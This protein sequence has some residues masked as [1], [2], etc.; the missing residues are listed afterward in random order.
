[1]WLFEIELRGLWGMRMRMTI[2]MKMSIG[3]RVLVLR[4][5][6]NS[7]HGG[8]WRCRFVVVTSK[9]KEKDPQKKKE[10]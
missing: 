10:T 9:I 3:R 4:R 2:R 8:R 5:V 7:V 1:M 6:K